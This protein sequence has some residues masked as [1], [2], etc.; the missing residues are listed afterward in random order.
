MCPKLKLGRSFSYF[1]FAVIS[2]REREKERERIQ[3]VGKE[4]G[5]AWK[6]LITENS[7]VS[8][9]ARMLSAGGE[10]DWAC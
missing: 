6:L 5:E 7:E 10:S 1:L 2:S 4:P 3:N 8:E 9:Y